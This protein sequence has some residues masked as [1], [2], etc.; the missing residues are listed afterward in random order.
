MNTIIRLAAV[1][2]DFIDRFKEQI[3]YNVN[4]ASSGGLETDPHTTIGRMYAIAKVEI[5]VKVGRYRKNHLEGCQT[6]FGMQ[7]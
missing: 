4:R 3:D 6:F 1:L 2:T 5:S 7:L